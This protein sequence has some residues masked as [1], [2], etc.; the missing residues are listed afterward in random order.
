MPGKATWY[1]S[2][3]L[4]CESGCAVHVKNRDGR[5]IKLEGNPD[6]PMTQG[7]L[8]TQCQASL[9][10]LYDS[11]RIF[12]PE[13][14]GMKAD[15][16][17]VDDH[18]IKKLR[19]VRDD[20]KSIVLLTGTVNSPSLEFTISK[21][22][23]KYKT[24][25]HIQMD[26]YSYSAILDAHEQNYGKRILPKYRFDK[27]DVVVSIDADFLGSWIS[28]T[29]FTKDFRQNRNLDGKHISKLI[30][31]ES[32]MSIT[33]A[34]ADERIAKSPSEMIQFVVA[35]D[36]A[37]R[38]KSVKDKQVN[39]IAQSL[40]HH[41]GKSLV[42]SG[43]NNTDLQILINR[44]NQHLGNVGRTLDIKKPSRQFAGSDTSINSLINELESGMV[45]A[46]LI[47][48]TNPVYALPNGS[49]FANLMKKVDLTV[50]F[51]NKQNETSEHC[52]I[53]APT[54][55]DMES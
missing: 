36:K 47:S 21:F 46:L 4:A 14:D 41:K 22:K 42:V 13:V 29:Q 10:E 12:H 18:V 50:S 8:C 28:P 9:I 30:Q 55:H 27:A 44:I 3:S 33:G 26:D 5:P 25:T 39:T 23:K 17:T 34:K 38:G 40:L 7:G 45:G 19:K 11:K 20:G 1:A 31:V 43:I 6:H 49:H 51:S 24:V 53:T 16:T 15:W 35:L 32:R 52:G 48:D 54:L 37:I 2:T